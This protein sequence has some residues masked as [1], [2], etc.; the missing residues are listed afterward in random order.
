MPT[1][2]KS[3]VVE[4]RPGAGERGVAKKRLTLGRHGA[5]TAVGAR[6]AAME[7]LALPMEASRPRP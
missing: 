3:F 5:M 7:A 2:A 6:K 1:G 4:Y